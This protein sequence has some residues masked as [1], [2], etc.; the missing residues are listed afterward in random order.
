MF[1]IEC[2]KEQ[3][4]WVV[5]VCGIS[6]C[7]D[8]WFWRHDCEQYRNELGIE[9]GEKFTLGNR[10]TK[11]ERATIGPGRSESDSTV[12]D[13]I[14]DSQESRTNEKME[15]ENKAQQKSKS[16]TR[17]NRNAKKNKKP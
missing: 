17:N 7:P 11:S 1:C 12:R 5:C 10:G 15:G 9:K 16:R 3:F 8:C 2:K 6:L 13:A 14:P 4:V